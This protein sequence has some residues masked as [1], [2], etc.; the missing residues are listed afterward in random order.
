MAEQPAAPP[1]GGVASL[2]ASA[3]PGSDGGLAPVASAA[4]DVGGGS[5][6]WLLEVAGAV[7][8]M[9]ATVLSGAIGDEELVASVGVIRRLEAV[10]AAE[11]YRRVGEVDARC[12][13]RVAGAGSTETWLCESQRVARADATVEVTVA[14]ALMEL[15]ATAGMFARGEIDEARAKV[16]GMAWREVAR[17]THAD[18]PGG[19][20]DTDEQPGDSDSGPQ[21]GQDG[22]DGQG[23]HGGQGGHAGQGGAAGADGTGREHDHSPGDAVGADGTTADADGAAGCDGAD[24]ADA[25]CSGGCGGC[26]GC[27][28]GAGTG[29]AA[30]GGGGGWSRA[31]EDAYQARMAAYE[32]ERERNRRAFDE[33]VAGQAGG[34]DR[35]GVSRGV[36]R[37]RDRQDPNRVA[38]RAKRAHRRRDLWIASQ[39]DADGTTMIKGKLD[40]A[41]VATLRAAVDALSRPAQDAKRAEADKRT[42]GQRRADALVALA[43][44]SL[45]A[46]DL[47]QV[48]R[49]RPH[50]LLVT[51]PEGLHGIAGAAAPHLDGVGEIAAATARML[52]CDASIGQVTIRNGEVL[53]AKPRQMAVSARQRDAVLARDQAC[54]GCGA[55][56]AVCQIHH[57]TWLSAGGTHDLS[58]LVLVCFDCHFHIHHVGWTVA[59]NTDGSY[60]LDRPVSVRTTPA[61]R[62]DPDSAGATPTQGAGSGARAGSGGAGDANEEDGCHSEHAT[63]GG[64]ARSAPQ[65]YPDTGRTGHPRRQ[66]TGDDGHHNHADRASGQHMTGSPTQPGGGN[67]GDP[68]TGPRSGPGHGGSKPPDPRAGPGQP[69]RQP[70]ASAAKQQEPLGEARRRRA[71]DK[72]VA[73]DPAKPAPEPTLFTEGAD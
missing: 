21:P 65:A 58:N 4:A 18:A 38:N 51:S 41:G 63:G 3:G 20:G 40:D 15:P 25:G 9:A 42:A 32:A 67:A 64:H 39:R 59:R 8:A 13:F 45:D 12:G 23:G 47:P 17:E 36:R 61:T 30:A 24:G 52:C 6:G 70:Q 56:A 62:S 69:R 53:D 48:T 27:D 19:S 43:Q 26:H 31:D 46:G 68:A 16:A 55:R 44:R 50:V 33:M 5:A 73:R 72:P 11:R 34:K 60:R 2:W 37:W 29:A 57:I 7:D 49:Q 14:R 54:V 35:H 28:G 10:L 1:A 71:P 22:Q 66:T